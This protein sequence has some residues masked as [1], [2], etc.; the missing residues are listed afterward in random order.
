MLRQ[1]TDDNDHTP[2]FEA[3][4]Y[5]S[6][7]EEN[8]QQGAVLFRVTASDLD[9]GDNGRVD[10]AINREVERFVSVD[11]ETGVV[12]AAV[13]LDRELVSEL[14]IYL[15]A[16]DRGQP[17][18]SSSTRLHLVILDVDDNGPEFAAPR[19][20]LRVAENQPPG[21]EVSRSQC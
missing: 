15:T 10:Y 8:N 3:D 9:I 13:S 20:R 4:S 1:V 6:S 11:R 14:N 18:R 2:T 17:P 12:R 5:E 16:T 21:T 19:L 7:I